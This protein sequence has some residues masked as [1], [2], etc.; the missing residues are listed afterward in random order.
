MFQRNKH[1][2]KNLVEFLPTFRFYLVQSFFRAVEKS[3]LN[4]L[5]VLKDSL[6]LNKTLK[7]I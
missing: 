5:A 1:K 7:N 3:T 6:L 4:K 2:C